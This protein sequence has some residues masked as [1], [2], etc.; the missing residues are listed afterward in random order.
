MGIPNVDDLLASMTSRQLAEWQAY[1]GIEPWGEDRA[2]LR[3]GI[4]ASTV[5]NFAGKSLKD[6]AKVTPADFMPY[7]KKPEKTPASSV[8]RARFAHLVKRED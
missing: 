1:F 5:A 4:V 2:D 3:A 7:Q 6:D 8:L